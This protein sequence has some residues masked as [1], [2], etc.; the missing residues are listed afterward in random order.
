M[1][2]VCAVVGLTLALGI[3]S[4]GWAFAHG[5]GLNQKSCHNHTMTGDYHCH[6]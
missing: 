5:G 3:S 6:R 1:K 2:R 4:I